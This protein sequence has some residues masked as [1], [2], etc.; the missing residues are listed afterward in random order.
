MRDFVY[1]KDA[2][3]MTLHLAEAEEAGGLFNVG[4]GVARTWVDLANASRPSEA[5]R[6]SSS[7][8]C[9]KTSGSNTNTIRARTFLQNPLNRVFA[10]NN[11]A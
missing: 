6:T 1:V 9:R 8:K 2:V 3:D 10:A 11:P 7:S 4:S 5:S